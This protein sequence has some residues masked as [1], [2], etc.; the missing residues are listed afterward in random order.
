MIPI[1]ALTERDRVDHSGVDYRI[2]SDMRQ[3]GVRDIKEGKFQDLGL[4]VYEGI[5]CYASLYW[6]PEPQWS[7]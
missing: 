2:A 3:F 5:E 1:L 7:E 6:P 4:V